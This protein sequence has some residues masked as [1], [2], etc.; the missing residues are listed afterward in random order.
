MPQVRRRR[1]RSL[2]P[3]LQYTKIELLV[4][5]HA[6]V[7]FN[8]LPNYPLQR[9]VEQ[10]RGHA[11][12]R[13]R[14]D[15]LEERATR[16][17]LSELRSL[18]QIA[19]T[20][21][22]RS[23]LPALFAGVLHVFALALVF[24]DGEWSVRRATVRALGTI[25]GDNQIVPM[26]E[27]LLND[28]ATTVVARAAAEELAAICDED[29]IAVL[30]D[31][32][33]NKNE[34]V[35][36]VAVATLEHKN[37]RRLAIPALER[38]L[39][40][41]DPN[42][43]HGAAHLLQ[44]LNRVPQDAEMTGWYMVAAQRWDEAEA[45][46]EV[47][48]PALEHAILGKEPRIRQLAAATLD[49]IGW[50]PSSY[51]MRASHLVARQ[52]WSEA[53]AMRFSAGPALVR[54]LEGD[55]P[56]VAQSAATALESI[57]VDAVQPLVEVIRENRD[58]ICVIRACAVLSRIA[59]SLR[60]R[61]QLR[62]ASL[63]SPAVSAL[64]SVVCD[65]RRQINVTAVDALGEIADCLP[66]DVDIAGLYADVLD[67]LHDSQ[68]GQHHVVR[69]KLETNHARIKNAVKARLGK[70]PVFPV[71]TTTERPASLK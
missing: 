68:H 19:A 24:Q 31:V 2:L 67:T 17:V 50:K 22:D 20:H 40:H 8:A 33:G 18:T 3:Q 37:N 56:S 15:A 66:I 14:V 57:G 10:S 61:P 21:P 43:R 39:R 23:E 46:G 45:L 6:Q 47:A 51:G 32:L 59:A 29:A 36:E 58:R 54:A 12:D 62:S 70:T 60:N 13:A 63:F 48:F 30:V 65:R 71:P 49:K 5:H 4:R 9:L 44:T 7:L 41:I 53:A 52:R 1:N 64:N 16:V 35:R 38:A 11:I 28:D 42:V 26:L 34:I 69:Q 27:F 25:W 55:D